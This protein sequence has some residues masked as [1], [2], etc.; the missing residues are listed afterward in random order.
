MH[1]GSKIF[2]AVIH[3]T[4]TTNYHRS[5]SLPFQQQTME[6]VN[7][8]MLWN[9]LV[10]LNCLGFKSLFYV[11]SFK[12]QALLYTSHWRAFEETAFFFQIVSSSCREGR[13][14]TNL[15][16]IWSHILSNVFQ[17]LFAGNYES[18]FWALHWNIS[19][20]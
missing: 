13:D 19:Y 1:K 15:V 14:H 10:G 7:M 9:S 4:T 8:S 17:V 12:S 16:F 5:I 20:F 3:T 6:Y 18:I 11:L 2:V